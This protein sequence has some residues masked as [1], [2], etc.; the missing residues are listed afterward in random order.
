MRAESRRL[1]DQVRFCDL[2]GSTQ[3][4]GPTLLEERGPGEITKET[5]E[6]AALLRAARDAGA[7]PRD[8]DG[9][10]G[11]NPSPRTLRR[12][13]TTHPNLAQDGQVG[14]ARVSAG[15]MGWAWRF[16]VDGGRGLLGLEPV[17][18]GAPEGRPVDHQ[19]GG[20]TRH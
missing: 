3:V 15:L 5:I 4:C 16:A 11:L 9:V 12:R 8:R 20:Y 14:S 18:R 17:L 2:V 19:N 1:R 13:A 7:R 10:V 6:V